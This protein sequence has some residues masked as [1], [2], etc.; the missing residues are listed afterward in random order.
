M[1]PDTYIVLLPIVSGA[2]EKKGNTEQY[3]QTAFTQIASLFSVHGSFVTVVISATFLFGCFVCVCSAHV[4]KLMK[5]S[6]DFACFKSFCMYF[7]KMQCLD[8]YL[9]PN[10][11]DFRTTLKLNHHAM[12]YQRQSCM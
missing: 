10:R 11:C 1:V 2:P 3:C 9:P 4:V 6:S 7:L 5:I 8:L 12:H